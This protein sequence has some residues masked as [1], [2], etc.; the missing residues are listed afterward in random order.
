MVL[1]VAGTDTTAVTLTYAIWEI[2]QHP[3]IHR[4]LLDELATL[5]VDFGDAQLRKLPYLNAKMNE[6]LRCYSATAGG[7]PRVV[8]FGGK[9]FAGYKIPAGATVPAQPYTV[10]R[11]TKAFPNPLKYEP[12][13]WLEPTP[14]MNQ[15][16]IPFGGGSRACLGK[17]L[18][19]TEVRLGLSHL[20]LRVPNLNLAPSCTE[21]SMDIEEFFLI[22]PKGH[23]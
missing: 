23:K 8:P 13:R 1:L 12:E 5:P 15:A 10:H 14:E 11:D 17:H 7:L 22:A 2:I 9:E 3:E 18:A 16:F 4:K 6:T 20:F 19:Q 21:E